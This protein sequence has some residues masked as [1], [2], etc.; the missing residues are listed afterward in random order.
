MLK[1]VWQGKLQMDWHCWHAKSCASN[2][3]VHVFSSTNM[4]L[5]VIS[6]ES[7]SL[8]LSFSSH[9]IL[10]RIQTSSK[11]FIWSWV[12][13]NCLVGGAHVWNCWPIGSGIIPFCATVSW[14]ECIQ[15]LGIVFG[16]TLFYN[17]RRNMFINGKWNLT[18]SG[19]FSW[20]DVLCLES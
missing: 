13:E 18:I 6:I 16:I 17:S 3:W 2:L 9:L 1:L 15:D 7:N 20:D 10:F 11:K 14:I 19:G 5:R 4:V 12:V 8:N